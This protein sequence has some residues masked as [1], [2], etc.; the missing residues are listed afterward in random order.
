M[1]RG[2]RPAPLERS[3]SSDPGCEYFFLPMN[4]SC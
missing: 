1:G 3:A 4:R 2:G